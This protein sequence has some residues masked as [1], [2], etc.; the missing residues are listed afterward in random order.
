MTIPQ[1][2]DNE[3]GCSIT[4][5]YKSLTEGL[6]AAVGLFYTIPHDRM[7][8]LRIA[9]ELSPTGGHANWEQDI[10]KCTC[11]HSRRSGEHKRTL[12]HLMRVLS[13]G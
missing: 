2:W 13:S 8:S 9:A 4:L 7:V 3:A 5:G 10:S 6:D 12:L 1:V 11:V